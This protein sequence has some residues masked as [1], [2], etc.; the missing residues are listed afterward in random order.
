M[1]EIN[2]VSKSFDGV[3]AVQ[4]VSL[5]IGQGKITS[6]IGPNGAGKT[7]L[8]NIATGFL[9]ADRGEVSFRNHR[10]NNLAPWRITRHGVARTFQNLRL[11]RKLT[12]LENVLLGIKGQRGEEF[13][14]SLLRFNEKSSE[15]SRNLKRADELI[16]FVGLSTHRNELADNLSYGQQK[17]LSIACCLAGDPELLL[18]DEPVA[19]VQPGMVEKIEAVLKQLVQKENNTV[20]LIEHDIDF[21]LRMS[22]VVIVMDDGRKITEGDPAAIKNNP[23]ILEAYLS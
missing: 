5:S 20:F 19:G 2:G 15:H 17:L 8:F 11:F 9:A 22:D 4:N 6:L 13:F 23:E 16:D 21:V 1:L 3:K 14:N 10:L 18:L 12:V 7:T